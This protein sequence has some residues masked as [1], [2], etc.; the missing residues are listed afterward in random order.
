M[1]V[2]VAAFRED[3]PE[4]ESVHGWL[5]GLVNGVEAF[6]LCD[7]ALSGFVRV[8]THPRVFSP[9]T[10]VAEALAFVDLLRSVPPAVVVSPGE[11]HWEIFTD[12]CRRVN[13]RGNLVPDAYF[14]A[15]AIESGCE[16]VTFDGDYARFPGL[17]W[18]RP[19]R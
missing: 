17:K 2:L 15:L 11:R 12:L 4:H 19:G 9:P 8:V 1:N 14:A 3:A 5:G 6:A 10:P 18:C 16:W 13:A 7:L